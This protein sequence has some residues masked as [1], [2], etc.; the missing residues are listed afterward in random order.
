MTLLLCV[1]DVAAADSASNAAVLHA[2]AL[3]AEDDGDNV[4]AL[5][6]LR[7]A[8]HDDASSEL[9]AF[10]LAR[11]ALESKSPDAQDL[12][13]LIDMPLHFEA[14]RRLK[15]YALIAAGR[16]SEAEQAMGAARFDADE[17]K[18]LRA[19]LAEADGGSRLVLDARFGA[20][21]DTNV[22][23]LPDSEGAR[24]AGSRLVLDG[25]FGWQPAKILEVGLVAQLARHVSDRDVL[26]E[27]DYGI[28]SGVATLAE[29]AGPV[30]L[31]ADFSGTIVTTSLVS[32]VFSTDGGVRVDAQLDK[33]PLRPGLY[34]RGGIRNFAAGNLDGDPTDRDSKIYGGGLVSDDRAGRWSYL[35]RGGYIAEAAQGF[36][37]RQ[38]GVEASG[39]GRGRFGDFELAAAL[40][41]TRRWY[42]DSISGRIDTR[43]SP[44]I[45]VSYGF[46]EHFGAAIGYAFTHNGST[47][48]NFRYARHIVRLTLTGSL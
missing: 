3:L 48:D 39:Y 6:L 22:T 1:A 25:T 45:D 11:L 47:A 16:G 43:L 44:S 8:H 30:A 20:E 27:Y 13:P 12:Q 31:T 23:L 2:R 29:T 14:S 46:A 10:D 36:A 28:A 4:T 37:Q 24:E 42:Y 7:Q 19:L 32:Q 35:V 9:I 26:A 34:G 38:R 33:A 40:S 41:F 17:D 18:E 21:R 15:V 5:T